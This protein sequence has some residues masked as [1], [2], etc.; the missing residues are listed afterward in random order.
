MIAIM[1][2][3]S[4]S[5]SVFSVNAKERRTAKRSRLREQLDNRFEIVSPL[6][7]SVACQ[8]VHYKS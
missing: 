1:R 4:A 5:P 8:R 3:E 2:L 6:A 7:G